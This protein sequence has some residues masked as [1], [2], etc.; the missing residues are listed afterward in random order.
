MVRS[1]RSVDTALTEMQHKYKGKAVIIGCN[2]EGPHALDKVR[3]FVDSKGSAMDY[4]VAA[5]TGGSIEQLMQA[6]GVRGIPHAFIVGADGTI[7]HSGHPMDPAF[8]A[9]LQAACNAAV[10]PQVA[11]PPITSSYEELMGLSVK[12]LKAMLS[13]RGIDMTGACEKGDL[14]KLV[15]EKASK[16]TYYGDSPAWLLQPWL[17]LPSSTAVPMHGLVTGCGALSGQARTA[18]VGLPEVL[19]VVS[20][21]AAWCCGL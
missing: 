15:V 10:K 5:D 17:Q 19:L 2:T 8:D 9:Q 3:R 16:V 21:L 18:C 4:T 12:E 20:S 7:T 13:E 1:M 14:A 6:A 11:L